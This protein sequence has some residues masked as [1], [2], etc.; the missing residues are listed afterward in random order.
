MFA[1]KNFMNKNVFQFNFGVVIY[2]TKIVFQKTKKTKN[3]VMTAKFVEKIKN[4]NVIYKIF[5]NLVY[6]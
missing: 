3:K 6:N 2:F 1:I 4:Y 5:I